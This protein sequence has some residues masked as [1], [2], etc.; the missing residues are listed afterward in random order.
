MLPGQAEQ[1]FTVR[2]Y[3]EDLGKPYNR[4]TSYLCPEEPDLVTSE[5]N[6][7]GDDRFDLS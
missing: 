2:K 1:Q 4:I 3:K 6:G 5:D 7:S